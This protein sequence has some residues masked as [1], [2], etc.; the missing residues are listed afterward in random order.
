MS[1]LGGSDAEQ[2]T[3]SGSGWFSTGNDSDEPDE[4]VDDANEADVQSA[5]SFDEYLMNPGMSVGRPRNIRTQ[6]QKFKLSLSMSEV[7]P[8][9][10]RDQVGMWGLIA[11]R[12]YHG[13]EQLPRNDCCVPGC[14]FYYY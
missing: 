7:F 11:S 5:T 13:R 1:A 9:S 14:S 10:L 6:K 4:E 2:A 12:E 3:A 8:L